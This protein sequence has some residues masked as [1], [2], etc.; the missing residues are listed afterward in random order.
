M[1]APVDRQASAVPRGLRL[2]SLLEPRAHRPTKLLA[3]HPASVRAS[4]LP[5]CSQ[6]PAAPPLL[7][8]PVGQLQRGDFRQSR[9]PGGDDT[10]QLEALREAAV[11]PESRAGPSV[12][13]RH[14]TQGGGGMPWLPSST[15]PQMPD[16]AHLWPNPTGS[17]LPGEPGGGAGFQLRPLQ[18]AS[19]TALSAQVPP[20]ALPSPPALSSR[21]HLFRA[22]PD[23]PG[24]TD[25]CEKWL[26]LHVH[27]DAHLTPG[28][29]PHSSF[30]DRLKF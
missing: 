30:L 11:F 29:I 4:S 24:P 7:T 19:P 3:S 26:S 15:S 8:V 1:A 22:P 17:L 13:T 12:G 18:T 5:P 23:H 9:R 2:L 10:P 14:G 20:L 28:F 27:E 25:P 16:S 21:Q 6:A